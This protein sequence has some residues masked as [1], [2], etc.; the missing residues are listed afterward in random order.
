MKVSKSVAELKEKKPEP[1]W[2]RILAL[3]VAVAFLPFLIWLV[4]LVAGVA[5]TFLSMGFNK[6]SF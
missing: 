5:W 3:I 6:G 2:M 1:V 4:G